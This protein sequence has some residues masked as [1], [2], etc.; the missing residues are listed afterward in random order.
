M[1]VPLSSDLCADFRMLMAGFPTGVAVVTTFSPE[2]VPWGMTCSSVAS[3]TVDP[4]TLLVC[5]RSTSPTLAA[6]LRSS[7]LAVNLLHDGARPQAE[8]FASGAPDRFDRVR[9][10]CPAGAGGPH[11]VDG[12]HLIGDC[13]LSGTVV[14]GDHVVVL[15]EVSRV[16]GRVSGYR[17]L[18]YGLRR[19]AS[20]PLTAG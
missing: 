14:V 6:L 10:R 20:W 19:Y 12:A 11:L 17:P 18:L 2:G 4:P 8:L 1:T 16:S 15:A 9:W 3:V 13:R 5:L 7:T